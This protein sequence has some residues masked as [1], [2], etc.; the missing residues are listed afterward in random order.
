[1]DAIRNSPVPAAPPTTPVAEAAPDE[2][3]ATTL[4]AE[5]VAALAALSAELMTDEALAIAPLVN[6]AMTELAEFSSELMADAME[7]EALG[8]SPR[9]AP[10]PMAPGTRAVAVSVSN[11][12]L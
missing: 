7:L 10:V 2:A 4:E 11:K 8:M 6:E 3:P 9:L 12:R 5:A 1:M